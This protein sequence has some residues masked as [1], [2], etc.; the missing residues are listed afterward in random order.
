MSGDQASWD[1]RGRREDVCLG[2][3]R[4][5]QFIPSSRIEFRGTSMLE[6]LATITTKLPVGVVTAAPWV[7]GG[8]GDKGGF[9][10]SS[11]KIPGGI[12]EWQDGSPHC[13]VGYRFLKASPLSFCF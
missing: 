5:H 2:P 10:S 3:A 4:S 11:Y 9:L 7:S 1:L 6:T 12:G 8:A 13:H